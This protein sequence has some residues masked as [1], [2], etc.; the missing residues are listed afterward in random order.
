MATEDHKVTYYRCRNPKC[1]A[2]DKDNGNNPP[3]P[4]LLNCWKCKGQGSMYPT[5]QAEQ[6]QIA[7]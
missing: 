1:E 7:V 5:D 6:Q 4:L 2:T 3:A